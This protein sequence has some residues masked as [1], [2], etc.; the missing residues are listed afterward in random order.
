MHHVLKFMLRFGMLGAV[1]SCS[2]VD[3]QASAAKRE[4]FIS[5]HGHDPAALEQEYGH[6]AE[7]AC[8][9]RVDDYLRTIAKYDFAWDENAQGILGTKFDKIVTKSPGLGMLAMKTTRCLPASMVW[10]LKQKKNLLST[11]S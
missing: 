1:A 7:A 6:E 5:A 9:V 11:N 10:H 4:Q 8:S 3:E 2:P